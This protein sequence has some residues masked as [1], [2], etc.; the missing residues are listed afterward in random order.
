MKKL[1]K[2]ELIIKSLSMLAQKIIWRK[3]IKSNSQITTEIH[4]QY[5]ITGS[6]I[7]AH[8]IN[9]TTFI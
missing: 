7:Q 5:L 4:Q 3:S 9:S 2:S 6:L 1:Y 8:Q